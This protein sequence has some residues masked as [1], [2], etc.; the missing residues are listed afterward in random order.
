MEENAKEEKM[1][2]YQSG[3]YRYCDEC[4]EMWATHPGGECRKKKKLPKRLMCVAPSYGK[5]AAQA[6]IIAKNIFDIS[7]ESGNHKIEI[8]IRGDDEIVKLKSELQETDDLNEHLRDKVENLEARI[9]HLEAEN[10]RLK[11]A[12]K[13]ICGNR[14]AEQ[15]PCEAK[16]ALREC[17]EK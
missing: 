1:S 5:A 9:S 17:E 3:D 16:E 12:L 14:C 4:G 8:I 10:A 13:S 7:L 6:L 15:N 2:E 11:E